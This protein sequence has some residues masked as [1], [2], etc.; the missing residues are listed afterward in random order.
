MRAPQPRQRPILQLLV[1]VQV[2]QPGAWLPL[3]ELADHSADRS[4]YNSVRGAVAILRSRGTVQTV[5]TTLGGR[6]CQFVRLVNPDGR[7][8]LPATMTPV[9]V[10]HAGDTHR[11][12]HL[13]ARHP[14]R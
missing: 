3:A 5:T 9:A 10:T 12:Y 7:V 6:R 2:Q 1:A 14:L 4:I 13:S 8:H 11:V